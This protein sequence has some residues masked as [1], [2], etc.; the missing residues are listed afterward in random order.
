MK[1][2]ILIFHIAVVECFTL[3]WQQGNASLYIPFICLCR[4]A[5]AMQETGYIR[6]PISIWLLCWW[7][8]C[9]LGKTTKIA[10]ICGNSPDFEL[11]YQI[12]K[13]VLQCSAKAT[14]LCYWTNSRSKTSNLWSL[15]LKLAS[16]VLRASKMKLFFFKRTSL[17][18]KYRDTMMCDT[19]IYITCCF[20][21]QFERDFEFRRIGITFC[22]LHPLISTLSD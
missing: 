4:P 14:Q 18:D 5:E 17:N 10:T 13:C 2:C 6:K 1:G 9:I 8:R 11:C 7:N 16:G 12:Q 3:A 19:W 21:G 20:R 15:S 22:M